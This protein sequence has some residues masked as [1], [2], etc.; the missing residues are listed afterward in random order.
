R[1][2]AQIIEECEVRITRPLSA[3]E[4]HAFLRMTPM[5]FSVPEEK[6]ETLSLAQI[7]IHMH[8]LLC[9]MNEA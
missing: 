8:V 6:L 4:S 2:H 1:D 9:R 7:T 3:D 5:T